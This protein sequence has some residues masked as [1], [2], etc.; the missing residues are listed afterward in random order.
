MSWLIEARKWRAYV[1]TSSGL[2]IVDLGRGIM[3]CKCKA[4][5]GKSPSQVVE[6]QDDI[7]W[8]NL[9]LL[10]EYAEKGKLDETP[11]YNMILG[12]DDTLVVVGDLH[13]GISQSLW[14]PCLRMLRKIHPT[15]LVLL[16]DV[17]DFIRGKPEASQVISFLN[18]LK[19]LNV[20]I[21]YVS[22]CSDSY[23][24]RFLEALARLA[25]TEGPREPQLYNPQL[26]LVEAM[27]IPPC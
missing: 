17:F 2:G 4:C 9:V 22:G 15:H 16:G 24:S 1:G 5:L 19:N 21:G 27:R 3:E 12:K 7:A 23:A 11:V 8:H 26:T 6:N 10:K 14:L 18:L 13:I 20:R 25:F